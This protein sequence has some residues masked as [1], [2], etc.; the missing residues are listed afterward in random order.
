MYRYICSPLYTTLRIRRQREAL[1]YSR[2]RLAELSE[3]SN[4]FLSDIER[5][6][7]GFS[8]ALLGRL[9]RVLGLSADYILFGKQEKKD[10]FWAFKALSPM[11]ESV[12]PS[13]LPYL[14][15]V[16][17]TVISAMNHKED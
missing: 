14:E 8:I 6:D 4:S 5:G 16:L 13:Q 12:T 7:R 3:I 11:I 15:N 17:K 9:A 10:K 1:G 2:E